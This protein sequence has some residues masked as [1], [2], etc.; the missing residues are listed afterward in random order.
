MVPAD[1]TRRS[2]PDRKQI[3]QDG[4]RA[5]VARQGVEEPDEGGDLAVALAQVGVAQERDRPV[6]NRHAPRRHPSPAHQVG[7]AFAQAELLDRPGPREVFAEERD[8]ALLMQGHLGR[9]RDRKS[10]R[11]N[12]SHGYISYAVFCLKKKKKQDKS[13]E[14]MSKESI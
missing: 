12:S 13:H 11:L 2:D 6:R 9:Q 4:Q 10:T 3:A 14:M 7:D 5:D 8:E 1:E